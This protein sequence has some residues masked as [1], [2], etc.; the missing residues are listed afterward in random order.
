MNN[1]NPNN[2]GVDQDCFEHIR[3][4]LRSEDYLFIPNAVT[5]EVPPTRASLFCGQSASSRIINSTPPGPL[6]LWFNSDQV[7]APTEEIGF[8]MQYEIV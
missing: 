7:Y 4:P 1:G 2:P 5:D 6:M 3:T 8:R